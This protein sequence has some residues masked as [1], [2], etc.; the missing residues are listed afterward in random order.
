MNVLRGNFIFETRK[1]KLCLAVFACM[2]SLAHGRG[3]IGQPP[4]RA[5][6]VKGTIQSISG[7]TVDV[8]TES[9]ETVKVDISVAQRSAI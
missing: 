5:D 2:F 9:H 7:T 4:V 8:L 6:L 3:R 1:R